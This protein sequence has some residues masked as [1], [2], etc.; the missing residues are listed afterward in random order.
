MLGLPK[1]NGGGSSP[2]TLTLESSPDKPLGAPPSKVGKP[3]Y[4]TSL[5]ANGELIFSTTDLGYDVEGHAQIVSGGTYAVNVFAYG[6]LIEPTITGL[7]P[8]SGKLLFTVVI[9]SRHLH[10]KERV[11]VVIYRTS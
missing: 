11:Q 2:L 4:Y 10:Y 6:K 7:T 1:N 9:P 5:E 8:S 3:I